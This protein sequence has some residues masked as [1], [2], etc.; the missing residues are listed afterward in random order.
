MVDNFCMNWY[1]SQRSHTSPSS[2]W[3]YPHLSILL[4]QLSVDPESWQLCGQKFGFWDVISKWDGTAKVVLTICKESTRKTNEKE[5]HTLILQYVFI[6]YSQGL[7]DYIENEMGLLNLSSQVAFKY[8]GKL[9]KFI[10]CLWGIYWK[11]VKYLLQGDRFKW[12]FN[13]FFH[14]GRISYTRGIR[15]HKALIWVKKRYLAWKTN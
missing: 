2:S 10:Q 14:C 9:G 5:Q 15:K 11:L 12:N 13:V 6:Y 3:I 1:I 7:V 4:L 8:F